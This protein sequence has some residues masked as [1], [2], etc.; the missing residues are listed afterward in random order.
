MNK[1]NWITPSFEIL[2]VIQTLS[3]DSTKF[4][5][6]EDGEPCSPLGGPPTS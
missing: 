4:A 2:S 3:C 1:K 5:D 6:F